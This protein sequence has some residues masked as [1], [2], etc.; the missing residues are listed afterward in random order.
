MTL[1]F[2]QECDSK[3]IEAV[4]VYWPKLAVYRKIRLYHFL[5]AYLFTGF[6]F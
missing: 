2:A 3:R 1:V 4:A 5:F 6:L